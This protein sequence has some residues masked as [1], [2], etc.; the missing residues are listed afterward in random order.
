MP[1]RVYDTLSREKRPLR[2]VR[3][4]RVGVYV[5]GM[6]VQ[7]EPHVGHARAAVCGDVL[8]RYLAY[9]GH[10]VEYLT[11]FTDVDDKIIARATEEGVGYREVAERN[12]RLFHGMEEELNLLPASRYPKA[13]EHIPQILRFIEALVEKGNAY[14]TPEG[15]VYFDVRSFPGYGELSG[16]SL[17]EAR[18][19]TRVE[20]ETNKRSTADFALWKRAREGEPAWASP[21]GEGR[22]GWHIECS[23]MAMEYLGDTVDVHGGGLDLVF[24]HHENERAQSEALTGVPF[25]NHWAE[26][27]LVT[28]GGE[29]MAKSTGNF[30]TISDLLAKVPGPVVRLYLLQTHYRSPI[31]FSI[32]Q[33][34]RAKAAH[35]R[36]RNFVRA[37][38]ELEEGG[39]GAAPAEGA[40]KLRTA[41]ASAERAFREAMDDDLNAARALGGLFDLVRRGNQLLGGAAEQGADDAALLRETA[42]LVRSLLDVL[43]ISLEAESARADE[44]AGRF[45]DLLVELRRSAREERNWAMADRIR[46]RLEELGVALE[47]GPNGTAWR[48]MEPVD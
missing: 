46:D 6:T 29:K 9:A 7:G 30:L 47:D 8:H 2:P 48:W 10:S 18:E 15:D 22:P 43:G 27:G 42:A 23:A 34:S 3:D 11:N 40:E 28:L 31:D 36:L 5:C 35:A 26:N 25:A 24:P 41:L 39:E 16:R 17:E 14:P 37:V 1:L 38:G 12:I 4:D 44:G 33:V 19:G 13:T 45:V 20:S 32:E 21:W